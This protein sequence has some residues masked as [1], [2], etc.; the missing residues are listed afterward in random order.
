[1]VLCCLVAL[2]LPIVPVKIKQKPEIFTPIMTKDTEENQNK[3]PRWKSD[4][5]FQLITRLISQ[6]GK[7]KQT[8]LKKM[9][10]L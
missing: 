10:E 8:R 2:D 1:M 5:L 7:Q 3:G 6:W 4:K 9:E